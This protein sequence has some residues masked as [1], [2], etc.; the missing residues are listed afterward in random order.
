MTKLGDKQRIFLN[1]VVVTA[2]NMVDKALFFAIS[3]I[4]AR[5]LSPEHFGE[6]STALGYATFFSI[7]TDLG[8][9]Q[10]L[11]RAV[12]LEPELHKEHLGNTHA[13]NS[14]MFLLVYA[15]M[16]LSLYFTGYNRDTVYLTL[17]F[18]LVRFG[19]E[20]M[21]TVYSLYDAREKFIYS[22]LFNSAFSV[23]FLAGTV[24][25]VKL[26]GDY[27]HLALVRLLAVLI[28]IT[29]LLVIATANYPAKFRIKTLPG[30]IKST[31]PF[32]LFSIFGNIIHRANI[33]VLPLM[34]GTISAGYFSN[35]YLFFFTLTFVPAVFTRTLVPFL[36]R[37]LAGNDMEKYQFTLDIFTKAFGAISFYLFLVFFLFSDSVIIGIF[38]DKYRG[39]IEILKVLSFGMPFLFNIA[40]VIITTLDRQKFNMVIHGISSFLCVVLNV[41]LI[42]FFRAPGA[43]MATV[44][45]FGVIFALSYL[46]L[47][48]EGKLSLR[49]SIMSYG[50]LIIATVISCGVYFLFFAELFWVVSLIFITLTYAIVVVI[51]LVKR[52]DIRII[53][54]TL[55]IEKP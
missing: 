53:R 33:L 51:F 5:Y 15:V 12:N 47:K 16:A 11:V 22:S 54:E 8:I 18:G 24:I 49:R 9:N 20:Y 19:N 50:Y 46:Y 38:G 1:T 34:Q 27:F 32:G 31:I 39:S 14:V 4:I 29:A 26:A 13:L 37:A 30:F 48:K 10:S 23:A 21:K 45:T 40:T 7:F 35:G 41:V 2:A 36:Y 42:Y 3:V 25:V 44:I 17:I 28:S 52:D 6:Y 55:G 43:A